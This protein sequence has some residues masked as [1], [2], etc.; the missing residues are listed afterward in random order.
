MYE[1]YFSVFHYSYLQIYLHNF[2]LPIYSL[3]SGF[4]IST[5]ASWYGKAKKKS[6]RSEEAIDRCCII[7]GYTPRIWGKEIAR[8]TC[9]EGNSAQS[10]FMITNLGGN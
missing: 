4:E 3:N 9:K 2:S 6:S 1:S 7:T 10:V 5:G 8:N